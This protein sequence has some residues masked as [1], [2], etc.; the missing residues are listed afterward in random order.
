MKKSLI[1]KV[2]A[3]AQEIEYLKSCKKDLVCFISRRETLWKKDVN[4]R[5][6]WTEVPQPEKNARAYLDKILAEHTEQ[7]KTQIDQR[8]EELHKEWKNL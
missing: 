4:G 2:F 7:I 8:I 1:T 5:V 3:L 6:V